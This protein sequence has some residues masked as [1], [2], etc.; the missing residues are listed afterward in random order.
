[1]QADNVFSASTLKK[2][3]DLAAELEEL[4]GVAEVQTPFNAQKVESSFFGIE[5]APMTGELP[6]TMEAI[7]QFK[8]DILSSPYVGVLSQGMGA[9]QL[10][11]WSWIITA[12]AKAGTSSW[13]KSRKQSRAMKTLSRFM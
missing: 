6:Q 8:A 13:P 12:Q 7:E 9:V 2:I 1:M 11:F 3:H 5:I 4:P 10:F